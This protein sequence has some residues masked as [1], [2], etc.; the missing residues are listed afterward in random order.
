V[1]TVVADMVAVAVVGVATKGAVATEEAGVSNLGVLLQQPWLVLQRR[2]QPC[3]STNALY[4]LSYQI[5]GPAAASLGPGSAALR[6][7]SM[8]SRQAGVLRDPAAASTAEGL[9]NTAGSLG[10]SLGSL[11]MWQHT[12]DHTRQARID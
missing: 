1:A 12:T 3:L 7:C 4:W 2:C 11:G 9:G 5:L 8:C 6:V 10:Y